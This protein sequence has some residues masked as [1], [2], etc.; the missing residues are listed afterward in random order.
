MLGN[1]SEAKGSE[2][3]IRTNP[4]RLVKQ[5]SGKTSASFKN[6]YAEADAIRLF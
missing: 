5:G 2:F 1:R 4:L 3:A 6:A